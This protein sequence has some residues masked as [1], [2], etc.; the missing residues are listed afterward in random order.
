[1][2]RLEEWQWSGGNG[3]VVEW[4]SGSGVVGRVVRVADSVREVVEWYLIS[5]GRVGERVS[6]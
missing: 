4:C 6:E 1:M 2:Q 5:G 3:V